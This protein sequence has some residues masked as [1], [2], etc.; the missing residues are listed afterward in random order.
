MLD[1]VFE[2]TDSPQ[3]TVRN[4]GWNTLPSGAGNS[5]SSRVVLTWQFV[6]GNSSGVVFLKDD[7]APGDVRVFSGT[8][9]APSSPG[10]YAL[11]YQLHSGESGDFDSFGN[12]AWSMNVII[13]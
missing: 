8:V 4:N 6:A 9:T 10:R 11:S 7:L 13:E 12:P 5:N 3:F 1:S 2:I